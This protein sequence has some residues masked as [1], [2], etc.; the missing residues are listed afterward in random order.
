MNALPSLL[1]MMRSPPIRKTV[2]P[3]GPVCG[4][5]A[6]VETLALPQAKRSAPLAEI[7]IAKDADGHWMWAVLWQTGEAGHSSRV[8]PKWG[9]FAASRADAVFHAA[10]ELIAAMEKYRRWLS[11]R[12]EREAALA[13]RISAWAEWIRERSG[14]DK[15]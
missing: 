6:D 14:V 9:R 5:D 13:G 8:G 4:P 11:G 1:D 2:D 15:W 3:D 7:Q 12:N 10:G